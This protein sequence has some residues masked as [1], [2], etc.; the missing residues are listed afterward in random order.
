MHF[1]ELQSFGKV[2]LRGYVFRD[3]RMAHVTAIR[4]D[5]TMDDQMLQR[6]FDAVVT[7]SLGRITRLQS[8]AFAHLPYEVDA[9]MTNIESFTTVNVEGEKGVG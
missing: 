5:Y 7:D 6:P 9:M 8:A 3:G 2:L 1:F 4:D